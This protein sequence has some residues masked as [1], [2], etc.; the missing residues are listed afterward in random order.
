MIQD[1]YK[2]LYSPNGNIFVIAHPSKA[3]G[4][5]EKGWSEK[6]VVKSTSIKTAKKEKD[7]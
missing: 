7:K 6:R 3:D 1:G 5:I 2:K 4:M